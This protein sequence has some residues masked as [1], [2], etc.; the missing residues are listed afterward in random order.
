MRSL[1]GDGRASRYFALIGLVASGSALVIVPAHPVLLVA[2]WIVSGWALIGLA[3][4]LRAQSK[5][6]SDVEARLARAW[7]GSGE[8][9]GQACACAKGESAIGPL[10]Q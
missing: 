8:M 3:G 10:G 2:G 7:A 5:D 9:P 1:D 4:A 6:A